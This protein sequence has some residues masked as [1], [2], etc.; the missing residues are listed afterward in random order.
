MRDENHAAHNSSAQI[1]DLLDEIFLCILKKLHNGKALWSLLGANKRL[2]KLAYDTI[3][4]NYST[5]VKCSSDF[6]RSVH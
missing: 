3:F 4:T 6:F 2:D 5:S 1:N